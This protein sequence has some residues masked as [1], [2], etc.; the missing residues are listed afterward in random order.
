MKT[1]QYFIHY[2]DD[3]PI[4]TDFQTEEPCEVWSRLYVFA[5]L[6]KVVE[7]KEQTFP[8]LVR[9]RRNARAEDWWST[10]YNTCPA[11]AVIFV[12]SKRS[13][14]RLGPLRHLLSFG[15]RPWRLAA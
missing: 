15:H 14:S 9:E 1:G 11:N 7:W 3:G 10:E 12:D 2:K 4:E 13:Q 8:S 5:S 6:E